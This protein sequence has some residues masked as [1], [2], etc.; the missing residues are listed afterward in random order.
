MGDIARYLPDDMYNA[1]VGANSPSASNVY[2]TINDLSGL[3]DN[4]YTAD[5][6]LAGARTVT[7]G[8]NNLIFDVSGGGLLEIDPGGAPP[9]HSRLQ[10]SH[11]GTNALVEASG[12]AG[13]ARALKLKSNLL[14]TPGIILETGSGDIAIQN[15]SF[16]YTLNHTATANRVYTWQDADGTIAFLSDVSSIYAANGTVGSGRIATLTDTLAFD[17]TTHSMVVGGTTNYVDIEFPDGSVHPLAFYENRV[18][19]SATGNNYSLQFYFNDNAG[20]RTLGQSITTRID[21]ATTP[22]VGIVGNSINLGNDLKVQ[23]NNRVLINPS[24]LTAAAVAQLEVRGDATTT[25]TTLLARSGGNTASQLVM[26]AQNLAGNDLFY[27]D[28]TGKFFHNASGIVTADFNARGFTD[29]NLLYVD[30]GLDRVGI[31]TAT[32]SIASKFTVSGGD[33]EVVGQN[34]GVILRDRT[35]NARYRIYIDS[36]G[37]LFTEAA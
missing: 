20:T 1:A 10:L 34:D 36:T 24:S 21:G 16:K 37:T 14:A 18:G 13:D 17:R 12:G 7:F 28:A 35:S 31:G 8:A 25:N 33:I 3:G 4:I 22:G 26:R 32:A 6:T 29:N 11:D 5:G 23:S 2:A 30:A 19:G 27:I 15:S 9:G